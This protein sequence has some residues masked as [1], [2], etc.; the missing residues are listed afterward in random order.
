MMRRNVVILIALTAVFFCSST[1]QIDTTLRSFFPA[2]IGDY[3]EYMDDDFPTPTLHYYEKVKR[4]TLMPNGRTYRVFNLVQ[5]R[6]PADSNRYNYYYRV[7]DSL[8]VY[9]F[10]ADTLLVA[11]VNIKSMPSTH[12]TA[13]FGPYALIGSLAVSRSTSGCIA[14]RR[15]TSLICS[16]TL[17]QNTT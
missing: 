13:L 6:F 4:D 10:L 9:R 1:A 15:T 3:W 16:L 5:F 2:H 8:R 11:K 14:R 7:D 17:F 12:P